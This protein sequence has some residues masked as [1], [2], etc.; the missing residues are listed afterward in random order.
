MSRSEPRGFS[1]I[2]FIAFS[3]RCKVVDGAP[4]RTMTWR[5][6]GAWFGAGTSGVASSSRR[7][8]CGGGGGGL[9]VLEELG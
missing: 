6:R 1:T 9:E 3:L 7:G 5:D 4:S 8:A 2:L